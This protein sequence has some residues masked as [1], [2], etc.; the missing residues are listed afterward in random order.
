MC[1]TLCRIRDLPIISNYNTEMFTSDLQ[2]YF[3]EQH[4]GGMCTSV[5]RVRHKSSV[6]DC[7]LDVSK[8]F[9][10]VHFDGM[11]NILLSRELPGV[12]LRK[13]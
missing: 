12:V 6:F 8:S 2:F 1:I 4:S 9:D 7:L 3:E 5:Q 13:N 10:C 11:S